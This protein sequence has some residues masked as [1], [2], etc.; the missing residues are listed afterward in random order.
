M[1]DPQPAV[2]G[3]DHGAD[4]AGSGPLCVDHRDARTNG[5]QNVTTISGHRDPAG[6]PVSVT[7]P[8]QR[9]VRPSTA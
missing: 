2:Q 9:S 4:G 8:V 6:L 5:D 3:G 7:S 1:W